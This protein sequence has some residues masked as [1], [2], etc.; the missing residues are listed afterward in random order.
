MISPTLH[1]HFNLAKMHV[2]FQYLHCTVM[3]TSLVSGLPTSLSAVH[4]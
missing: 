3:K 1:Q 4:L 2:K